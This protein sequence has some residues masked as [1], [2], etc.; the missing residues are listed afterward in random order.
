[1]RMRHRFTRYCDHFTFNVRELKVEDIS[2]PVT[3]EVAP[4]VEG[5]NYDI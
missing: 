4:P 3:N 1:M 5:N 2:E